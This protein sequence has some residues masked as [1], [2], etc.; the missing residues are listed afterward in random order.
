[1]SFKPQVVFYKDPDSVEGRTLKIPKVIKDDISFEM[2]FGFTAPRKKKKPVQIEGKS[3]N[4]NLKP[5]S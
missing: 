2:V 1:M 4:V 5:G 3:Y